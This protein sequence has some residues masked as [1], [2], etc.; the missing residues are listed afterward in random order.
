MKVRWLEQFISRIGQDLATFEIVTKV[1]LPQTSEHKCRC[2]PMR[3][4][5]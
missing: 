3:H 4:T 1:V 2:I 5:L